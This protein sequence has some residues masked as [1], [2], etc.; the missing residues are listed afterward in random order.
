M[1]EKLAYQKSRF[2]PANRKQ[3]R[4]VCV[5]EVCGGLY[6]VTVFISEVLDEFYSWWLI[7][8]HYWDKDKPSKIKHAFVPV[9]DD[10]PS[11]LPFSSSSSSTLSSFKNVFQMKYPA[12]SK[13]KNKIRAFKDKE[14]QVQLPRLSRPFKGRW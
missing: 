2:D 3:Q 8:K 13:I 1:E 7:E 4:K 5:G 12:G 9:A 14:Y 6:C 11:I 10:P